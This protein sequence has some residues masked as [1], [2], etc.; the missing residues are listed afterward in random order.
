[1]PG[2]DSGPPAPREYL[3]TL[4]RG[5]T[6]LIELKE[7]PRTVGEICAVLGTNRSDAYRILKTLERH[8]FIWRDA[9][10]GRYALSILLWE[11]GV[12]AIEAASLRSIA[13]THVSE[14]AERSGE[15][16]HLS[17]YDSGEVVYVDVAD[18]R[19]PIRSY[20]KL[21]GRAPAY[22]VAT[23][24]VLLAHKARSE[25][26]YI[27]RNGLHSYSPHTITD[28]ALLAE[29]LERVRLDGVAINRGEWRSEV[30]GVAVPVRDHQG[31]VVAAIGVSGPVERILANKNVLVEQLDAAAE[32]ITLAMKPGLDAS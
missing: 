10:T 30:G 31:C 14:L 24:K 15:T 11:L 20:T 17:V 5:L 18:G 8:R 27:S 3:R 19:N 4:G 16:I 23:G 7:A 9:E 13:R 1:M 26:D 12:A 32:S 2:T 28:A 21:G 25:W 29:E 6:V 22:C